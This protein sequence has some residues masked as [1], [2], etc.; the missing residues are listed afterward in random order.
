MKT[1][2]FYTRTFS[3]DEAR[4]I[5]TTRNKGNRKI[6]KAKIAQY[7]TAMLSGRWKF[8]PVPLIFEEHTGRLLD[9]QNRLQAIVET[10][11]SQQFVV[12]DNAG[13]EIM[14]AID[15]GASRSASDHL[16]TRGIHG[17]ASLAPLLLAI[18]GYAREPQ[19]NWSAIKPVS[20]E[21]YVEAY[22]ANPLLIEEADGQGKRCNKEFRLISRT[23]FSF[24]Y[25]LI[26]SAGVDQHVIDDFFQRLSYGNDL[27]STCPVFQYR[28]WLANNTG[29]Y[30]G[31]R[32]RRQHSINNILKTFNQYRTGATANSFRA[33]PLVPTPQVAAWS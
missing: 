11:R 14:Q 20:N 12:C 27:A 2:H 9:G 33:A 13:P 26:K 32:T 24:S 10:G 30:A 23:D 15:Q 8:T 4:E 25:Y 19:D 3:P 17:G 21:E 29:K 7:K 22:E 6:K 5:L 1:Y 31:L 16:T 28:K 18:I